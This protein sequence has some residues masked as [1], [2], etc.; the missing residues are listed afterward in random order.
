MGKE[1]HVN[2]NF[3]L[4]GDGVVSQVLEMHLLDENNDKISA[5]KI[6]VNRTDRSF[7]LDNPQIEEILELQKSDDGLRTHLAVGY[8]GNN[9]G[10]LELASALLRRGVRL[11][12]Y[13]STQ[14]KIGPGVVI[15]DHCLVMPGG[16]VEPFASV[17]N[18]SIIWSN[19]H[20]SHHAIVG[21]YCFV[22]SGAVICGSA[23][24]GSQCF[25]GA[26]STVIDE[27][28]VG[29][30]SVVGAGSLVRSN[31][32]ENSVIVAPNSSILSDFHL[33]I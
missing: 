30:G 22:A 20:V 13:V 31:C 5:K 2:V 23:R 10:R 4:I 21:D 26:N 6:A 25:L 15:G 18:G 27:V 33:P 29:K 3:L 1:N 16:I 11:D 8:H 9:F 17:G 7:V 24:I 32:E 12:T 19:S 14:A 28:Y